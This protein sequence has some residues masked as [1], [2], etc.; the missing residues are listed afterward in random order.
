M[1][2][3]K[4][5]D[6]APAKS[7]SALFFPDMLF[8]EMAEGED[9]VFKYWYKNIDDLPH[10]TIVGVYQLVNTKR[11]VE[12]ITRSLEPLDPE[13]KKIKL[14]KSKKATAGDDFFNHDLSNPDEE[15]A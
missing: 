7:P 9:E 4:K 11:V 5:K 1:S 3:P 15:K 13:E 2:K 12:T 8:V 6:K 10:G 14:P